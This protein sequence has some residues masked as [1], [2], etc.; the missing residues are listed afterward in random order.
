MEIGKVLKLYLAPVGT[1]GIR[2]EKESLSLK[3]NYGIEGDKFANKKIDRSVMIV[4]QKPYNMAK[5]KGID[6]PESALGEN[7]L[8]DF[9]PHSLPNNSKLQIG[10]V[11]LEITKACTLCN[12]LLKYDKS[13]PKLILKHRGIYCK[14]VKSGIINKDDKVYLLKG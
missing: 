8:L 5:D 11:I 12:H 7:I 6:L 3:E 1:S 13:L 4:G 10:S 14:V 2:E 9:D